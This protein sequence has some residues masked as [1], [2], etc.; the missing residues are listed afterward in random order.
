MATPI[1]STRTVLVTGTSATLDATA[2]NAVVICSS[3]SATTVTLP[4]S[5]SVMFPTGTIIHVVQTGAGAVTL[6]KTGS[7][8]IVPATSN[9]TNAGDTLVLIKTGATAWHCG[10]AVAA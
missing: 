4:E 10:V 2:Q 3:G 7:D 5:T 1:L 9:T 6:A 8:T